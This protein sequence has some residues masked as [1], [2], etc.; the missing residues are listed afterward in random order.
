MDALQH[1]DALVPAE[2]RE[3]ERVA[4]AS[5]I[6]RKKLGLKEASNGS[7]AATWG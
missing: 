6:C 3:G 7:G 5:A 1:A 2:G 4:Q